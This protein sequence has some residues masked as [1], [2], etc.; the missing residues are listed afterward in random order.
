MT[1]GLESDGPCKALLERLDAVVA[2]AAALEVLPFLEI[3]E[4]QLP[5][6]DRA[7]GITGHPLELAWHGR[8]YRGDLPA[9]TRPPA[10]LTVDGLDEPPPGDAIVVLPRRFSV[11]SLFRSA[12]AVQATGLLVRAIDE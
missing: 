9:G 4:Q 2:S 11:L 7:L 6:A 1:E 3:V 8:R 12:P 10:F 5:S